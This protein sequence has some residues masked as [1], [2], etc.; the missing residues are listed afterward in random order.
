MYSMPCNIMQM[1]TDIPDRKKTNLSCLG[2]KH[3]FDL[4]DKA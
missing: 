1:I 2:L 3:G 4:P